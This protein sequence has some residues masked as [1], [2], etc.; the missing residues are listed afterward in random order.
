MNAQTEMP[1]EPVPF[2]MDVPGAGM[3]EG[4]ITPQVEGENVDGK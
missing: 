1:A 3:D 4:V 2:A